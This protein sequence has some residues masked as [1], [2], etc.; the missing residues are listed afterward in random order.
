MLVAGF[1][2]IVLFMLLV[3][4]KN[5]FSDAGGGWSDPL[6]ID[7]LFFL[8]AGICTSILGLGYSYYSW[9]LTEEE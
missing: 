8:G 2:Y 1:G 4:A 3:I 7:Y 9:M 5:H 6:I